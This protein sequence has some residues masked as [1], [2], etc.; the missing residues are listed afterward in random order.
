MA[1]GDEKVVVNVKDLDHREILYTDNAGVE[2]TGSVA[3][4]ADERVWGGNACQFLRRDG[5]F[6]PTRKTGRQ[7]TA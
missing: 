2:H 7:K 5:L 4:P 6:L 1:F 3:L